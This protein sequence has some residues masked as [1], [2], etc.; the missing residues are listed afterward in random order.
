M[1]GHQAGGEVGVVEISWGSGSSQIVGG[2]VWG[3]VGSDW[4]TR[5]CY[6]DISPG[7]QL[8]NIT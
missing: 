1:E 2:V 8:S 3:S 7:G 6:S 5:L 4:G